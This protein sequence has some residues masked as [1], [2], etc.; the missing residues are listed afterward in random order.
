VSPALR[1]F[2]LAP[3]ALLLA[4]VLPA[5]A[6]AQTGAV[7]GVRLA[8]ATPGAVRF[9]VLTPEPRLRATSSS[10]PA[11]RVL[12]LDGF[13]PTGA[14][15]EPVIPVRTLLIAVPP[16]GEVRLTA[17]A[18][19]ATVSE[20]V[21]LAPGPGLGPDREPVPMPR[22]AEA[23]AVAGTSRP[24]GA[25]LLGVT[26]MRN[27]R[28][29]RV[30]I[31]P[32]AYEPA[33]RRLTVAGRVD[34]ELA[35]T[36]VGAAGPAAEPDDPFEPIYRA[37]LVNYAQGREW[38]RPRTDVLLAAARRAGI[39][40]AADAALATPP[41]T[42][43]YV[44]R[45]WIK[46][47]VRRTGFVAVNFSRLRGLQLFDPTRPAPFD[48]LRVFT[49][50]GRPVLPEDSYCDSCDYREV[51]LG[52]VRD[53]S[54]P[55]PS[56]PTVDGPADGFFSENNDAFYF[57]AQ[58]PDGWATD[59]DPGFQDT[60]Y[61][62][63]PYERFNYYYLTV[64]TDERPVSGASYPAAP[65]RIGVSPAGVRDLTIDGSE[66][67]VAT[68]AGRVHQEQDLEYWPDASAI[69]STLVWE[70]WFWRSLVPGQ[71]FSHSLDLLDADTTQAARF[72]LR[73]WGLSSNVFLTGCIWPGFDHRLDASV[74]DVVFPRARSTP[75]ARSCGAPATRWRSPCR[76]TRSPA[77]PR[78]RTAAASR[79]TSTTTSAGC[80]RWATGS[81]SARTPVRVGSATTSV[82][83]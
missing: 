70:K 55:D 19:E 5:A 56:T 67:P 15:G 1:Q 28:V 81:N 76:S 24:T 79:S 14:P 83:S 63:H 68:V 6:P 69:R 61:V 46:M 51:A 41:D 35:V 34:V 32:V 50:P 37:S 20:G 72:R 2:L 42:S 74:N 25:R 11:E 71:S 59:Y 75:P 64:G 3:A 4:A 31:E 73:H 26:W 77:A 78:S 65:K 44:G 10:E 8:P 7:A 36:P 13:Q 45:T 23:Y 49:W 40:L 66:T 16:L 12:E 39:P 38:R 80:G 43:V 33:A 60:V 57:F 82:R 52:V 17:A 48:S 22:R 27:Q 54:A 21:L 58:G 62:N 9:T 47:A 53:V 29:A 18:T 30:A